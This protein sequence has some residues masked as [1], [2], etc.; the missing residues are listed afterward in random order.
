MS[1][2]LRYAIV[3]LQLITQLEYAKIERK[4]EMSTLITT[5]IMR[6]AI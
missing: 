2:L 5:T 6:R 1:L 3:I 4:I